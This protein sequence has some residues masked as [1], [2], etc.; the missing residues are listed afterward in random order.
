MIDFDRTATDSYCIMERSGKALISE[1]MNLVDHLIRTLFQTCI[2]E[3]DILTDFVLSS[4][5]YKAILHI[6]SVV[7]ECEIIVFIHQVD[8]KTRKQIK[9][10]SNKIYIEKFRLA[11]AWSIYTRLGRQIQRFDVTLVVGRLHRRFHWV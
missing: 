1:S 5:G 11:T 8:P 7:E 9:K 6:H 4:I 2:E 3:E 10:V